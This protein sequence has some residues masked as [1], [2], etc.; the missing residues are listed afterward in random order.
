MGR[1]LKALAFPCKFE[2]HAWGRDRIKELLTYWAHHMQAKYSDLAKLCDELGVES[3]KASKTDLELAEQ[4]AVKY[5][6][7]PMAG[8]SV[9]LDQPEEPGYA[10]VLFLL[11]LLFL[12]LL[13]LIPLIPLLLT[14]APLLPSYYFSSSSPPSS[15]FSSS[16]PSLRLLVL[17][18]FLVLRGSGSGDP[19]FVIGDKVAC[20]RRYTVKAPIPGSPGFKV[21]I[22]PGRQGIVTAWAADDHSKALV[23]FDVEVPKM[24]K[25]KVSGKRWI[26]H[27]HAV[28]SW[29]LNRLDKYLASRA[30]EE[31]RNTVSDDES[32]ESKAEDTLALTP[33]GHKWLNEHLDE[34]DRTRV[35]LLAKW[36]C[37]AELHDEGEAMR[38]A[39][40]KAGAMTTLRLAMQELKPLGKDD[41]LVCERESQTG[42]T[43]EVW[44]KREFAAGEICLAPVTSTIMDRVWT[45]KRAASLDTPVGGAFSYPKKRTLAFDGRLDGVLDDQGS[46]NLF[47]TIE[48]T[49]ERSQANLV[50]QTASVS[51][52]ASVLL[53]MAKR[54]KSTWTP[55]ELPQPRFLVNPKKSRHAPS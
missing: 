23:Q 54:V 14:L 19:G 12:L 51:L 55:E 11:V 33:R 35:T 48:R 13:I 39:Y 15:S 46:G 26:K 6:V 5:D 28:A 2:H 43:R 34:K 18:G 16:F 37:L 7:D 45:A 8:K 20:V 4:L 41:L 53:P 22:V 10:S 24:Y 27:T 38:A 32:G 49:Q 9:G 17:L 30:E 50:L 31:E 47:W 44:T 3:P 40:C 42:K 52:A 36:S 29:N 21:D 1:S 25:D